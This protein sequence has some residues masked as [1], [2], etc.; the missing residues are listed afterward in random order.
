M[1]R[2]L[3]LVVEDSEDNLA[4]VRRLLRRA[5]YSVIE[6]R[7]GRAALQD[8]HVYR[9]DLI[10]LDMS[11]PEID[12]WTVVRAL[13][14]LPEFKSTVVVALTAHAMDGDRERTLEAGCNEFLTKPLDVTTFLPTIARLLEAAHAG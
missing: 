3:V 9:P 8:A 11:L 1:I 2:P 5:P 13:R 4:L 14:A 12:G 7:D 6:A 10:L